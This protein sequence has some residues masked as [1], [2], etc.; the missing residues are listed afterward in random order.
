MVHTVPAQHPRRWLWGEGI[1]PFLVIKHLL[2]LAHL[3]PV[4]ASL[5]DSNRAFLLISISVQCRRKQ[6]HGHT[7][8][9]ATLLFLEEGRGRDR[10]MQKGKTTVLTKVWASLV[11]QLVNNPP[12]M[13]ET[14]V[15]FLGQE[16]LLEKG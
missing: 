11:A 10:K 16:N 9:L 4:G 2:G 3:S 6:I 5:W 12:A 13:Q 7:H 14:P 1:K 15:R 8:H